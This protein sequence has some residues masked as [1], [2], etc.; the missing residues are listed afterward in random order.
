MVDKLNIRRVAL[1]LAVVSAI[2][3]LAC[4]LLVFIA[5]NFAVT[6][7]SNLFHGVDIT[8]TAKAVTFLG[9]LLGLIEIVVYSLIAGGLFAL[10]YN[11]LKSKK[12]RAPHPKVWGL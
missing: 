10:V 12:Q 1:S 4:A 8:T 5:P 7:F 6:L 3:Y 11:K 9:T 2:L